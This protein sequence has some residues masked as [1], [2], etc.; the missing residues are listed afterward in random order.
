MY[1]ILS[2][3]VLSASPHRIAAL[4]SCLPPDSVKGI[5]IFI[6]ACNVLSHVLPYSAVAPIQPTLDC[7]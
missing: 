1:G 2:Q 5:T 6:G 3:G 4:T 7:H